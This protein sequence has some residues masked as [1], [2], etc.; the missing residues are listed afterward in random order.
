[1]SKRRRASDPQ[2]G[3]RGR[4]PRRGYRG[5]PPVLENV[6]GRSGRDSGVGQAR[7]SAEGGRRPQQDHPSR[8]GPYPIAKLELLCYS[9]PRK[10]APG[11]L[12]FLGAC[13][14]HEHWGLTTENPPVAGGGGNAPHAH[15]HPRK[16]G[17]RANAGV[18]QA[19]WSHTAERRISDGSTTHQRRFSDASAT[20]PRRIHDGYATPPCLQ[21]PKSG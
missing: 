8:L 3:C 21:T 7:P 13:R 20:T 5:S 10:W 17:T 18:R 16:A 2:A 4:S 14:I 11:P 12:L 6:G 1:M 15:N 19:L 9:I